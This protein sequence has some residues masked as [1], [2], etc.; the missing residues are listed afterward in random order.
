MQLSLQSAERT[1]SVI[2]KAGGSIK[3]RRLMGFPSRRS[4]KNGGN[5]GAQE[6]FALRRRRRQRNIA[7]EPC[8][9]SKDH[10]GAEKC[11]GQ[12]EFFAC[13]D[14][15]KKNA[16]ALKRLQEI[17][18]EVACDGC[19]AELETCMGRARAQR[20][21]CKGV[22][23]HGVHKGVTLLLQGRNT[24]LA[25]VQR[26]PCKGASTQGVCKGATL[27]LQGRNVPLARV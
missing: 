13:E 3:T 8:P 21:S 9:A 2:C 4:E 6:V 15:W 16:A 10:E 27:L 7:R 24:P 19:H 12:V 5:S 25:R 18:K 14:W 20:S 22:S 17:K 23:T 11:H 1:V 26:F